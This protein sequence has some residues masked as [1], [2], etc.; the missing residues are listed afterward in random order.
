MVVVVLG[1]TLRVVVT[2]VGA[3][4]GAVSGPE[5]ASAF[6][7]AESSLPQPARHTSDRTTA[8]LRIAAIIG[9]VRAHCGSYAVPLQGQRTGSAAVVVAGRGLVARED[10]EALDG[11]VGRSRHRPG[12]CVRHVVGHE[13]CQ[14]LVDLVCAIRVSIEADD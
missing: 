1:R 12:D 6:E 13:G 4:D 10:V 5:R 2:V 7:L 3:G 11:H 8:D 9:L 14:S